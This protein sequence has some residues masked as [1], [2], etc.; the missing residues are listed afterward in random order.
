MRTNWMK[1]LRLVIG[2]ALLA[3]GFAPSLY[4]AEPIPGEGRP[5]LDRRLGILRFDKLV[6]LRTAAMPA[7]LLE[8]AVIVNRQEEEEAR[9]PAFLKRMAAAVTR[10]VL[11]F[12]S[13]PAAA[14]AR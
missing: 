6:V 2:A 4:H 14:V 12:C 10:A 9:G 3:G 13:P 11:Q 5:L 7:V 1:R 8:A